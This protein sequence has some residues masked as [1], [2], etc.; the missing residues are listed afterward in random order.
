[1]E[2]LFR[3]SPIWLFLPI[4]SAAII[5]LKDDKSYGFYFNITT[6]VSIIIIVGNMF[7][8]MGLFILIPPTLIFLGFS[9]KATSVVACATGYSLKKVILFSSI[10]V[11][12]SAWF[13]YL[14]NW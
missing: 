8:S 12:H 2:R 5:G 10:S 11:T 13:F 14:L 6:I 3:L 7:L 4:P 9:I 1:M